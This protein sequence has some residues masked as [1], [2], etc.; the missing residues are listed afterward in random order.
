[1][2]VHIDTSRGA[3]PAELKRSNFAKLS[4]AR[5]AFPASEAIQVDRNHCPVK[6]SFKQPLRLTDVLYQQL[7]LTF[8]EFTE[9]YKRT[10]N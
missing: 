9:K 7:L 10:K 4:S 3:E 5:K 1:M 8:D 2:S 6:A